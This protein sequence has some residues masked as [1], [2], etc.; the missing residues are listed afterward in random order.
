LLASFYALCV[1]TKQNN[2]KFAPFLLRGVKFSEQKRTLELNEVVN[3]S[4]A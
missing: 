1:Q 4:V 3:K 2:K